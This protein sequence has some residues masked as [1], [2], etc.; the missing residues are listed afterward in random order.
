MDQSHEQ[1]GAESLLDGL[2][3]SGI[4]YMFANAGTDFPPIIEA[5]ARR[6]PSAAPVALTIPHE[7]A[8]VAMAHGA[9]LVTGRAQAVMVH[10]NVGLANSV[11]GVI[12]AASDN[13]PMLVMSGRTPISERGRKGA[14]MTPIQYGQEMFDQTSLVRDLVKYSYEMRYP[15]QGKQLV[16]RAMSLAT[17]EPQGPVYLSLPKEPLS[18]IVPETTQTHHP[19]P[20]SA[21]KILPDPEAIIKLARLLETA[22][23]PVIICQRGDTEGRL[24]RALSTLAAKHGIAVFEPFLLRNVLHSNDPALQGYHA[25]GPSDADLIIVLDSDT[26]WIEATNAPGPETIVVHIGPDP[27]FARMPVRGFRTDLAISSDSVEAILA[28]DREARAPSA[29]LQRSK[30]LAQSAT[31]RRD[32]AQVKAKAG[33][34]NPM[35]A[36]WISHCVSEIMDE[37]AVA[38]SEL[39]LLPAYMT[40]KGPNRLF[41]NVHAGGLGWAMPAA[42]GA[43]LMRPDRLTIACMG[44]GSYMF[45]NPVACHQIA[46]ALRL[47]ILT[48]IKNN[49][50][51]NAVRRSVVN[52]YPDGS[53]AMSNTVPLTSLEPLPDFAAIAR[54]SRA[55]AERIEDGRELPAALQRAVGIIRTEKRQVLLDLRCAVSDMH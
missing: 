20:P 46:E 9:Y 22:S 43:Q 13:I 50:M 44:D 54:A 2:S 49:A 10:V 51:W 48:I 17:S 32:A 21:T 38:F 47:P 52:G 53:A 34:T 31:Q 23:N 6:D 45:A 42:L 25:S 26:P 7:T 4:Q 39:G 36:E 12:N 37:E 19:M 27:H 24:S 41:N 30:A 14:R 28:V 5:L 1:T 18:E 8:A 16:M 40:L 29:A 11:M 33:D 55:H 15:E 3:L 35:S